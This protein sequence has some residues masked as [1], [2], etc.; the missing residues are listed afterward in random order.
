MNNCPV[1]C[2][3]KTL[4]FCKGA[5]S[6]IFP[7]VRADEVDRIRMHVERNATVSFLSAFTVNVQVVEK[8]TRGKH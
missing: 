4:L 2:L 3:G 8:L 1:V 5:D 7:R 6:S